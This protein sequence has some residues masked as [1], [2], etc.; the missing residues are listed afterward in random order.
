MS[1]IENILPR[2]FQLWFGES[3]KERFITDRPGDCAFNFS[4]K[5]KNNHFLLVNFLISF[6]LLFDLGPVTFLES[7][8]LIF[9]KGG[10]VSIL[11]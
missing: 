9:L 3:T 4:V 7:S 2:S 6:P 10:F 8:W 1:L 5:E 11:R